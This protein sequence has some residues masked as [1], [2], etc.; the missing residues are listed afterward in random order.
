M[1]NLL[2][3]YWIFIVVSLPLLIMFWLYL[4][5]YQIIKSLLS[6]AHLYY[7]KGY[8]ALFGIAW[9]AATGYGIW[10]T[11]KRVPINA[12][13]GF[14][15]LA[16]Y[17]TVLYFF[18]HDQS[19]IIPGH[20]PTWMLSINDLPTYTNTFL[21]PAIFH[22][23]WI[24]VLFFTP[25]EKER[26]SWWNFAVVLA[27]PITWYIIFTVILPAIRLGVNAQWL[28]HLTFLFFASS[29]V[30]FFFFLLRGSYIVSA[31]RAG[32][33]KNRQRLLW[34]VPFFLIFPV[35]GLTLNNQ[36]FDFIFGNFTAPE[37][38]V[39]AVMNGL[40]LLVPDAAIP[41]S[42]LRL[43]LFAARSITFSYILYFFLVFLPFLPFSVLAV[44][45]LGVG[46]LMLT[47]LFITIYQANLLWKTFHQL[48]QDF[49][50]YLLTGI[51]LLGLAVLPLA[52]AYNYH[53]D[54][55]H[56]NTAL[57]MI[58]A[59]DLSQKS[60]S[61]SNIDPARI[62]RVIQ[63]V[64]ENKNSRNNNG[65][66]GSNKKKKPYLTAY[67]QSA[68]LDNL[69][70]SQQKLMELERI[71][72]GTTPQKS[73]FSGRRFRVAPSRSKEVKIDTFQVKSTYVPE[74]K[75][76]Q[77]WV[78]LDIKNPTDLQQEYATQFQLPAGTWIDNY[79][80]M[81]EGR[82]EYGILAEKRAAT[83]VYNRIVSRRRDPGLL[84]YIGGNQIAFKVF[85]FTPGQTRRTGISFIH[86][87]PVSFHIGNRLIAL[88]DVS[89]TSQLTKAMSTHWGSYI[90]AQV[91]Q[92]APLKTLK[93]YLHLVVD[94]SAQSA[95]SKA[96]YVQQIQQYLKQHPDHQKNAKVTISNF[97]HQTY[98]LSSAS[99]WKQKLSTFKNQGGF[100]LE[101][102]LKQVYF[103]TTSPKDHYPVVV[104][105]SDHLPKAVFLK[106]LAD[107]KPYLQGNHAFYVLRKDGYLDRHSSLNTPLTAQQTRVT[108]PQS[109]KL[110]M[111]Q[112]KHQSVLLEDNNQ[113]DFVSLVVGHKNS[114]KM[115]GSA[116]DQ[117]NKA[118]QL[119]SFWQTYQLQ[120]R[121]TTDAFSH[122]LKI[123][124]AS[125][126]SGIMTPLTSY[127]SLENEA[128]KAALLAKQKQTLSGNPLLD[129]GE[130]LTA[131]S[132]PPLW[133]L[134]GL[135]GLVFLIWHHRQSIK[136]LILKR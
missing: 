104:V 133:M 121:T 77:T 131:M 60:A 71:F 128:Q 73:R 78:H 50:P 114:P 97:S 44:I 27:I 129:A 34:Q 76:W 32:G 26:H 83:W 70:L 46:F 105:V 126:Q 74:G 3:P 14:I 107:F 68:V 124:K 103:K 55:Y 111:I 51:I 23:L 75:Y 102:A 99:K 85:P 63:N 69:T 90:P 66:F 112:L 45:V 88:G 84:H 125:F 20:I 81:I 98:D 57:E 96:K 82:K 109:R 122:R 80:L 91:K 135:I 10:A 38:Y 18:I 67:Y 17:V 72:L 42:Y 53:Q 43:A 16:Y 31:K 37:F 6:P 41:N 64:R 123:I 62:E 95:S 120:P 100:Y 49:S 89:Q 4:A 59:P 22:S 25:N 118:A 92:Q 87:A 30:V 29:T 130:E 9:L 56:L 58:Y 48:R 115:N 47:P 119:W 136:G 65:W 108:M 2:K 101:G 54:K 110:R 93:P 12:Y 106:T 40:L 36:N 19:R 11:V 1:K 86:K 52:V 61:S 35:L 24:L 132:E 15:S 5:N 39:L 33:W 79:Y 117:W 127:I 134:L 8:G 94:G 113:A 21:M 13:Y 28:E 116:D 7:W